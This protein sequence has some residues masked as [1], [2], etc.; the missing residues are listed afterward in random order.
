MSSDPQES[1]IR[2]AMADMVN[3]VTGLEQSGKPDMSRALK[4]MVD[5]I[6]ACELL[7]S[8]R[9]DIIENLVFI[10]HQAQ[11]PPEKRKRGVM[12]A[13]LFYVKHNMQTVEPLNDAWQTFGRTIENLLHL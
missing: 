11:M 12:K 9:Q 8:T 4:N 7:P 6:L 13:V 5:R 10:G 2:A 1:A 3:V